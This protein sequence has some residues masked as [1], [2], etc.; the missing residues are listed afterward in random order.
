MSFY[1]I[2]KTFRELWLNLFQRFARPGGFITN[3]GTLLAGNISAQVVGFLVIPI[4][5]RLYNPDDFGFMTLISS[6]IGVT[7]VIACFRY[8]IPIALP[9]T[10]VKAQNILALCLLIAFVYSLFLFFLVPFLRDNIDSLLNKEHIKN[11]IWFV[12]IGVFGT[13]LELPLRYWYI[14]KKK[15]YLLSIYQVATSVTSA[16]IKILAGVL[17]G[18]LAF[19]LIAGNV[20]G[21]LI[22]VAILL[23][24]FINE[25]LP[26]FETNISKKRVV[27]V[28]KEFNKFPTYN[29]PTALMNSFSQNIPTFLFAYY[30]SSEIVGFYGLA[31][32]VLRKPIILLSDAIRKVFFQKVS[33]LQSA[34]QSLRENF[35]KATLGLVVVG[36]IPFGGVVLGG[37]W[38]FSVLFG[39]DWSTAGYYSQLIAPWLFLGFI[40]PPATQ[41]ILVKQKLSFDL[42]WNIVVL[43]SRALSIIGASFISTEPGFALV[44]FSTVGIIANLYL[45]VFAFF[46]SDSI[47]S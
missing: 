10:D 18:S 4:I 20:I 17:F 45:I 27:D 6:L 32:T 8:E 37:E 35:I 42:K 16:S 13:G 28:A 3:V 22:P 46:L 25:H 31:S 9:R 29:V 1:L 36:V 5:T 30:F 12:P 23:F 7:S 41:I 47:K 2:R 26:E 11:L 15:F 38:I 14:R 33:E 21:L 44:L 19:W 24:K 43:I 34:G 39:E 40:N